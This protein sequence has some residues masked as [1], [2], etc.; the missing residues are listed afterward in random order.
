MLVAFGSGFYG[1]I[2]NYQEQ[3]IETK[4]FHVMF[5]PLFPVGSMFVTDSGFR[6]RSGVDIPTHTTSVLAVY[7]RL[8]TGL[9][10]AF[11]LYDVFSQYGTGFFYD[12]RYLSYIITLFAVGGWIYF[13]F[14]FGKASPD[15]IQMRKKVNS[16]TGMYALPHWLDHSYLWTMLDAFEK[17]YKEKYPDSNWKEDLNKLNLNNDQCRNLFGIAL[18]NCMVNNL[19]ENDELYI[20]ADSLYQLP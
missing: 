9:L 16:I 15:D 5:I 18:F 20:K 7:A 19:P 4:F 14:I 2:A 11:M 12:A 10:A 17:R 13:C 8:F 3:W 6:Q 1:K